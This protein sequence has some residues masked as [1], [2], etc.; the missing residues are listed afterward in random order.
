[1]A[2]A[3]AGIAARASWLPDRADL[4]ELARPWKLATFAIAMGLL[5]YGAVEFGIGDWDVGVTL[6]MG[7]LTYVTAP[8]VV[9]TLV[10]VVRERPAGWLM[11]TA[12]AL[13]VAWFVVDGVYLLYHSL[14]GNPIYRE[15][16]IYAS[17]PIYF[18]AGF[19][20]LFRGSVR[21]ML[22]N[23]GALRRA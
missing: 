17:T 12:A 13:V 11:A 6:V 14:A 3:Q 20:W 15:D 7:T 22:A 4:V 1:V 9:R 19:F 8:W 18:M 23:L 16:N 21:E 5:L 2:A 10:R